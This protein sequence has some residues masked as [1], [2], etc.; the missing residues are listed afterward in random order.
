[1]TPEEKDYISLG[2]LADKAIKDFHGQANELESAIGMLFVGRKMGWK[3][4]L[5][6]HDKRTIKKYEDI[7]GG[8]DVRKEFPPLGPLHTKSLAWK[9]MK[10]VT[11]FWKAVTGAI[12]GKRST[13]II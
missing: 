6:V 13:E 8:I 1:M 7:L 11:N 10:G 3:I 2:K 5:L 4:M 12:P 9:L